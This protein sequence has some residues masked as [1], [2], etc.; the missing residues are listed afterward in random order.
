[1]VVYAGGCFSSAQLA[2][3]GVV[4][5]VAR[6]RASSTCTPPATKRTPLCCV[7]CGNTVAPVAGPPPRPGDATRDTCP[8]VR[9]V[10]NLLAEVL[11]SVHVSASLR[12]CVR[13]VVGAR[14]CWIRGSC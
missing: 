9:L 4:K 8:S 11:G 14:V 3:Y 13:I 5:L 1:M 10:R 12:A 6:P 7:N 2:S